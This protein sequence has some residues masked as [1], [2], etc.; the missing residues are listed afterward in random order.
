LNSF[1]RQRNSESGNLP[2]LA[3]VL[4]QL[5]EKCKE[6]SDHELSEAFYKDLGGV[7]GAIAKHAE[8]VEITIRGEQGAQASN[9]LSQLF[10]SLVIVNA[11]GLPTRR[12]PL[13]S[14]FPPEMSE[15]ITVLVRE[16]LL[17][18]EGEGHNATVSISHETLFEAW[19]SLREYVATNK[20]QLMDQTLLESRARKWVE[21]GRPWFSG[22]ASG[23]ER[24]D[25]GRAGIPT[26]LAKEYLKA[27]RWG[28]WLR[29]V[30]IVLPMVVMIVLGT[31]VVKADLITKHDILRAQ[32][33]FMS[34][35]VEPEMLLVDAG[36]FQQGDIH[37]VGSSD[38]L[39]LRDVTIN[40]FLIGKTEVTFEEYDRFVVATGGES[41]I[42]EGWGRGHRPVI[43]VS[44]DDATEYAEWLSKATGKRYRFPTESEWEYAARSGGK[45][46]RWSGTS[47]GKLLAEY[48]VYYENS[49]NR[50]APV[51]EKKS[52]GLGLYDMSGN[53]WEW[54]E[55][56]WHGNYKGAPEDGSAW[57]DAGGADCGLRVIRGG[58][59]SGDPEFVRSSV[60]SR[61]TAGTRYNF[62][63]FRLAQDIR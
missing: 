8:Q 12:R 32:S 56:C 22:L 13:R 15:F 48:A 63:G 51:G 34:I 43:N 24:K 9:R 6:R 55:D 5:F 52:N 23:R 44:W 20:K 3:F 42:D 16:R 59:G 21:M 61:N 18:T 29:G 41:P 30:G 28:Q 36:T 19:P 25:F 49:Q 58:S 39:P 1:I 50:T 14:A 4:N 40:T 31:W 10:Q 37:G 62:I 46:E 33:T 11:E 35:H 27:S 17:H 54:V 7:T 57:L 60:R 53:V 2:L 47:D 26:L 45:E 38:E